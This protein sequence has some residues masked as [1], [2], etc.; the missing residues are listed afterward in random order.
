MKHTI[1]H[2]FLIYV[3]GCTP[4]IVVLLEVE[5]MFCVLL[6]MLLPETG[7]ESFLAWGS[8]GIEVLL[9]NI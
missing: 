8:V 3:N 7:K 2:P 4:G 9:R 6:Y 5:D 1:L